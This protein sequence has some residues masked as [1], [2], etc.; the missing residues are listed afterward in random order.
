M[1]AIP[2]LPDLPYITYLEYAKPFE[3]FHHKIA[4]Y[5]YGFSVEKG[6]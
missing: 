2:A 3:F 4:T 5:I 1:A 6:A